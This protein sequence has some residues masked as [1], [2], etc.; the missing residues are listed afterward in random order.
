MSGF[1]LT[2]RAF[3]RAALAICATLSI[4]AAT[5][6]SASG[7][8]AAWP[9]KPIRLLVPTNAG[10]SQDR[11]ARLLAPYL[12]EQLDQPVIV[13]NKGPGLLGH[14]HFLREADDGYT[15]LVSTPYP[16]RIVD[17]I[18]G[19]ANF[20]MDEFAFINAQWV[21][22]S[23]LMVHK[24]SPYQTVA[25]LVDDIVERPGRIITGVVA[26][27]TGHLLT[28]DL[29]NK[30]GLNNDAV[31]IVTYGGGGPKR[32]AFAGG[33]INFSIEAADGS[34]PILEFV[35]P[36]AVFADERLPAW[37]VPTVNEALAER[38]ITLPSVPF[39]FLSL[40]VSAKF[41][42]EHPD[43]WKR[44]VEANR[45][46]LESDE[47]QAS[48]RSAKIGGDWRGPEKT[49]ALLDANTEFLNGIAHLLDRN[50][51]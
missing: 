13:E 10:G 8:N 36:L 41:R 12:S 30:L 43:R 38:N 42:E 6:S 4:S 25:D 32:A 33:H 27:S 23:V 20:S 17:V 3:V 44:L 34:E 26:N 11:L 45:K 50:S 15:I 47:L 22:D 5:T 35:R 51:E 46:M 18:L 1:E 28:L 39:S 29:V 14:T 48:L 49:K 16:F 7:Q 40:A 9:D 2:R 19:R 37:D 31:R 21:D 24:D